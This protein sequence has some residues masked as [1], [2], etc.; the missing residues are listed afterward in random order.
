ME[1]TSLYLVFH[2]EHAPKYGISTEPSAELDK[3]RLNSNNYFVYVTFIACAP[4]NDLFALYQRMREVHN[5]H[6]MRDFVKSPFGKSIWANSFEKA[7]RS[8][9]KK[10]CKD[11]NIEYQIITLADS[12]NHPLIPPGLSWPCQCDFCHK[13]SPTSH[14]NEFIVEDI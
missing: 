13:P 11:N 1:L 7:L 6:I 10:F 4:H 9:A 14:E 2:Q 5:E 3:I 8:A 12:I